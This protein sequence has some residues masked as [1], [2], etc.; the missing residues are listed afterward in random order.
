MCFGANKLPAVWITFKSCFNTLNRFGEQDSFQGSSFNEVFRRIYP[1]QTL[2][3][4]PGRNT[5]L[6]LRQIIAGSW[7]QKYSAGPFHSLV[8]EHFQSQT[9]PERGLWV[10][11]LWVAG[12]FNSLEVCTT[13]PGIWGKPASGKGTDDVFAVSLAL[14]P[15]GKQPFLTSNN[16]FFPEPLM[17]SRKRGPHCANFT[18]L[19][20]AHWVLRLSWQQ[21]V[22]FVLPKFWVW[23]A[24][25]PGPEWNLGGGAWSRIEQLGCLF[26]FSM[27]APLAYLA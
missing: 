15:P 4:G 3:F 2:C 19:W 23:K 20:G 25:R 7:Y 16:G 14:H 9:K 11:L 5:H 6:P 13:K 26:S 12:C 1:K 17:C 22:G 27:P 8:R 24:C 18:S 10:F 21:V